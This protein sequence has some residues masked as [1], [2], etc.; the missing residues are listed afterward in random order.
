V[1]EKNAKQQEGVTV[2][3]SVAAAVLDDWSVPGQKCQTKGG[4]T[5]YFNHNDRR[6]IKKTNP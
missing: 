5:Q 1:K 6:K 2:L 4:A 3:E